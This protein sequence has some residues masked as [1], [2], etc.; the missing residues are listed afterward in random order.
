MAA[1]GLDPVSPYFS[2]I[3]GQQAAVAKGKQEKK[4]KPIRAFDRLL[5]SQLESDRA[6]DSLGVP[7]HLAH[8]PPEKV[9]EALLDDVHSAGDTLKDR[10]NPDTIVAY[11]SAVKSFVGYVVSRAFDVTVSTSGGNV[12]KRKKFTQIE[13]IDAKLE[14]LAR[15]I[16]LN[17]KNQLGVLERIEEINGLLI[18]LVS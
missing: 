6:S 17:Q 1:S 13:V 15:G 8:L 11:K 9:L 2:T 3:A 14:E 4:G 18:D 5:G 10:Q 16:L 12:L 7:E